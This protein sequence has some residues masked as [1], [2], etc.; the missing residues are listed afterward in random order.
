MFRQVRKLVDWKRVM[1]C[2][3]MF[4][5]EGAVSMPELHCSLLYYAF[6]N[7][8]PYCNSVNF[9]IS[10]ILVCKPHRLIL[11]FA[12]IFIYCICCHLQTL[13]VVRLRC[14][15]HFRFRCI[16]YTHFLVCFN[17]LLNRFDTIANTVHCNSCL[18]YFLLHNVFINSEMSLS[19]PIPSV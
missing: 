1:F 4:F 11:K 6:G 5:F 9:P 16:H 13:P 3:S 7:I 2:F 14:L 12:V 18:M 8:E 10:R 15:Y 17:V 19:D